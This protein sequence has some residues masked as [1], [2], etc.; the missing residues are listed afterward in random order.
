[1]RGTPFMEHL[2][3]FQLPHR[4]ARVKCAFELPWMVRAWSA[5]H[6]VSNPRTDFSILK[7]IADTD[8]C[9]A[10]AHGDP[11]HVAWGIKAPPQYRQPFIPSFHLCHEDFKKVEK[12]LPRLKQLFD[13]KPVKAGSHF[14]SLHTE[15]GGFRE[16]WTA[17]ETISNSIKV[18]RVADLTPLITAIERKRRSQEE[19]RR[20]RA[21]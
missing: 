12:L 1:M 20:N 17:L 10:S 7:T 11:L 9:P 15:S 19:A 21:Y 14:C 4:D 2:K 16:F 18:D 8:D 13:E 3:P 6:S 5:T